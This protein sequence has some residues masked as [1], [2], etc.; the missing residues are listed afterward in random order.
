M[1]GAAPSTYTVP[2]ARMRQGDFSELLNT[3]YTGGSCP[4]VLYIPNTNGGTGAT[5]NSYVCKSN[6][7]TTAPS[8]TLQQFGN[9]VT[10]DN[11]PGAHTNHTF[12]PGQNVF[13]PGQLDPVAQKILQMYPCPNYAAAGKSELR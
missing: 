6:S 10:T 5:S 9:Q 13:G 11:G 2:T 8:G 4:T 3:T 1:N 12:A 7:M